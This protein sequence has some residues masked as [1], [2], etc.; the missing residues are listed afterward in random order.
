MTNEVTI[1]LKEYRYWS[2][3]LGDEALR[4]SYYNARGHEYFV[5]VSAADGKALRELRQRAAERFYDAIQSGQEP[6]EVQL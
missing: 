4:I 3:I 2:P 1:R 6:G 5:I